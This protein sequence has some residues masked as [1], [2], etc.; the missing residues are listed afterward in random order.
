MP[1][2]APTDSTMIR[3]GS[4]W[5]M[6][7]LVALTACDGIGLGTLTVGSTVAE[8]DAGHTPEASTGGGG[9]G[10]GGGGSAGSY[11]TQ[12]RAD[13]GADAAKAPSLLGSPLCNI[14][15]GGT[16]C[17]P[18]EQA[19]LYDVVPDGGA[20]SG[21][22]TVETICYDAGVASHPAACHVVDSAPACS[23]VLGHQGEGQMCVGSSD[24]Q[25]ELEC[26]G[27]RGVDQEGICKRYCCVTTC[28][29]SES[30][31]DIEPEFVSGQ[32]V[33]VCASGRSCTPLGT[34]CLVGT[35]CT[36]VNA[37][38]GQTACITPGGARVG[39]DC[40]TQNCAVDLACISG[41]CRQLCKVEGPY[42]CLGGST[43]MPLTALSEGIGICSD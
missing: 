26:V 34:D 40:L 37:M 21:T 11:S 9:G 25:A 16:T 28:T 33:P 20:D 19:C 32:L 42:A 23:T 2:A 38:T 1:C 41:T 27:V 30:F 39:G 7:L 31:C 17:D 18:D 15:P 6:G 8:A 12:P 13:A 14:M 4:F 29:G 5:A 24:C 3:R 36:V 10:G 43:C 35:T 22:C